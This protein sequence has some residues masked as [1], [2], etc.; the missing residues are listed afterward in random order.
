[1]QNNLLYNLRG[2]YFLLRQRHHSLEK[3]LSNLLKT[4]ENDL[5][6]IAKRVHYYC[7]FTP[8]PTLPARQGKKQ[9]LQNGSRYCFDLYEYMRFFD[10]KLAFHLESGDVNYPTPI[11]SFCK[12]RPITPHPSN[13]IIL[14][15][16]KKR[17]FRFLNPAMLKPEYPK[18]LDKVFFR[19]G[20]YQPHRKDFMRKFFTHKLVDAGHVGELRDSELASWHK[21]KATLQAHLECKFILSLEGY[22][23]ATNLKWIMS[24]N[25]I[26]L[27]PKPKFETWFMEGTLIPNQHFLC[28]KEDFSDLESQV[29]YLLE[30]PDH[31]RQIINNANAYV[32]QFQNAQKE[33]LIS[34]LVLR[35]YFYETNQMKVSEVEEALFKPRE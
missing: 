13:N 6:S 21:G 8:A 20:C 2:I 35:K 4:F 3:R 17:H 11:P 18:K 7:N 1:M 24:S 34:L 28:I 12:S 27:M 15:L 22:D 10:P 32:K 25:S 26:A 19:G 16:D 29:A 23:V 9:I 14:K 31:A 33:D 5:E 30:H